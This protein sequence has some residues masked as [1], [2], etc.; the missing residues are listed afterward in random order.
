M[1]THESIYYGVPMVGIPLMAD[2][3]FNI[4]TY[5]KKG[6]AIKIELQEITT[7]TLTNAISQVLENPVYQ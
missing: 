2:Q 6:V 4:K 7:E 5:V 3:H 1:G